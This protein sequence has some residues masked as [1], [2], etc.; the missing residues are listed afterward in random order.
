MVSRIMTRIGTR[1]EL[2]F[3]FRSVGEVQSM[4]SSYGL[5]EV[6]KVQGGWPSY[7]D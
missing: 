6:L 3:R 7:L 4:L 5:D 1:E 2:P